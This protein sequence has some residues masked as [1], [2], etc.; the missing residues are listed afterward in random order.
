MEALQNK[1][2]TFN[3]E[4]HEYFLDGVK[5]PYSVTQ[6]IE[7]AGLVDSEYFTEE[8]R[9]RGNAVHLATQYLDEGRLNWLSV[10]PRVRPYVEG[11]QAFVEETGF[12][13]TSIEQMIHDEIYGYAGKY[14]RTCTLTTSRLLRHDLTRPFLLEI[15]SG[16][17]DPSWALQ[18]AAYEAKLF[19]RHRRIAVQ[20]MLN[21]RYKL[22]HF[23]DPNDIKVF[24]ALIT[25]NNWKRNHRR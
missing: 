13:L 9:Q 2:L 3:E 10:D 19:R 7:E 12:K 4:N 6:V 5:V 1:I 18:T 24:R 17:Y 8:S 25:A 21:S 15:K 22:H 16:V 23:N 20:L 11:Y 14:D